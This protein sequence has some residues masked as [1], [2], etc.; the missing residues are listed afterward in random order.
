VLSSAGMGFKKLPQGV[1]EEVKAQVEYYKSTGQTPNSERRRAN[2]KAMQQNRAQR[3]NAPSPAAAAAVPVLSVA[4]TGY[5]GM[6]P[7]KDVKLALEATRSQNN[8]PSVGQRTTPP[9]R[10]S[11]YETDALLPPTFPKSSQGGIVPGAGGS[12][13]VTPLTTALPTPVASPPPMPL[14]SPPLP[15]SRSVSSSSAMPTRKYVDVFSNPDV[16]DP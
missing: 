12:A 5:L 9:L 8:T 7:P 11:I 13:F 3:R 14:F 1:Q 6:K 16:L 10:P 2:Q 15:L 4:G